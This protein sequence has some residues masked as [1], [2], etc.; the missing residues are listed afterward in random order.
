MVVTL[1]LVLLSKPH[2]LILIA[3]DVFYFLPVKEFFC[4]ARKSE[5]NAHVRWNDLVLIGRSQGLL[6]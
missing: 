5:N 6:L 2:F 4:L 3:A 1:S